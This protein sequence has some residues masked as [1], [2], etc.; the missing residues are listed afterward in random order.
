[1]LVAQAMKMKPVALAVM[2]LHYYTVKTISNV[3][4][5]LSSIPKACIFD[6]FTSV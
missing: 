4:G 5:V 2:E 6:T 3:I 1:M